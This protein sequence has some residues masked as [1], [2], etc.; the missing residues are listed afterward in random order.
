MENLKRIL[1]TS[2][3]VSIIFT[4]IFSLIGIICM[5]Y[6]L[7]ENFHFETE[8][9][10]TY[11]VCSIL[12][13]LV[14]LGF[15]IYDVFMNIIPLLKDY[16]LFKQG[17]YEQ[18]KAEVIEHASEYRGVQFIPLTVIKNIEN[19]EKLEFGRIE[20]TEIGKKYMFYYLKN[21]KLIVF[22]PIPKKK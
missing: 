10:I 2:L 12:F 8:K 22:E 3:L 5:I 19:G 21:S 14:S 20:K 11:A 7:K 6:L 4:S 13:F 1:K 18:I 17:V 9:E 15:V 16:K